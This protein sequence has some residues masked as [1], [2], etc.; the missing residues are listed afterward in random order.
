MG[1]CSL[2]CGKTGASSGSPGLEGGWAM[3]FSES[4]NPGATENGRRLRIDWGW[5]QQL[6]WGLGGV[7]GKGAIVFP[8]GDYL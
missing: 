5:G 8:R 7:G 2:R 6:A 1:K 3:G 4:W